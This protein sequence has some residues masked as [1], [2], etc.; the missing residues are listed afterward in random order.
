MQETMTQI[1]RSGH[2]GKCDWTKT[3]LQ[4]LAETKT[5]IEQLP[6]EV[7]SNYSNSLIR[8]MESQ[9]LLK[10]THTVTLVLQIKLFGVCR[11]WWVQ[12]GQ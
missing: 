8:I 12:W 2:H 1:T 9:W 6:I 5:E 10:V 11:L 7:D 4:P 3:K